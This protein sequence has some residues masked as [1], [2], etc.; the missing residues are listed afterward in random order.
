MMDSSKKQFSIAILGGGIGGLTAAIALNQKGFNNIHIYERRYKCN[1]VGA[2]I[3]LWA[4]ATWVLSRLD[5]LKEINVYGGKLN[6]MQRW[7]NDGEFLGAININAIDS[8]IGYSSYAISKNDFQEILLRKIKELKIEIHYNYTVTDIFNND[9]KQSTVIFDNGEKI[10][11]QVIIGAEGRMKSIAREYII[12]NNN[13][14]YQHYVNWVGIVETENELTF[15]NNILDYWGYGERFGIVPI[16]KHKAYWAGCKAL[17][18]HTTN[19]EGT[20][21]K[22][23]LSIFKNWSSSIPLIIEKTHENNI[24]RFEVFDHD[25][26]QEWYKNNVCLLGDA[27][28]ASLPT[29]G[30]GACQAIEDAWHLAEILSGTNSIESA[31]SYYQKMRFEKTTAIT[32]AGRNF[33]HSLFNIDE[34][35][36][37]ERNMNAKN[38]DLKKMAQGMVNLWSKGLQLR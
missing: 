26:I 10:S 32:I 27:A 3:V 18:L 5:L 13:P 23:L 25:P 19:T 24:K 31:F 15:E 4:N 36:C 35:F 2:G 11:F 30:Q 14:V 38:A 21:K 37:K 7:T 33:A 17:P 12:G 16:N 9:D 20:D 6:Q 22:E 29:S 34:I 8:C 1:S 28:H